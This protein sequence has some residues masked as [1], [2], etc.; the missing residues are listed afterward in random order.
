MACDLCGDQ[1]FTIDEKGV[2]HICDCQVKKLK[3]NISSNLQKRSRIPKS[4]WGL[5]IASFKKLTPKKQVQESTVSK[6]DK[7]LLMSELKRRNESI[8]FIEDFINLPLKYCIPGESKVYWIYGYESIAGHTTLACLMGKALNEKMK[9]I[10]FYNMQDLRSIFTDFDKK[11][12]VNIEESTAENDGF[13]L[14]GLFDKNGN[15]SIGNEF[16]RLALIGFIERIISLGK[17]LIITSKVDLFELPDEFNHLVSIVAP[18]YT[19]LNVEGSLKQ[20]LAD[21]YRG[22]R[23]II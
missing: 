21:L 22:N 2:A 20:S 13:I 14:D 4:Y 19:S 17:L 11:G 7:P 10:V 15:S 16:M 18:H 9:K 6:K 12:S 8:S 5:D 23:G 3:D 1:T